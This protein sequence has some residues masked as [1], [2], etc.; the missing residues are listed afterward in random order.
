MIFML[1]NITEHSESNLCFDV[2]L[3][4]ADIVSRFML[5]SFLKLGIVKLF[6]TDVT[7][8]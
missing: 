1:E 7:V 6:D 8:W 4:N 3:M 2:Q 5:S